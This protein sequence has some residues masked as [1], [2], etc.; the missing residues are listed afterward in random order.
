MV[1]ARHRYGLFL[2]VRH[3]APIKSPGC[4]GIILEFYKTYWDVTKGKLRLYNP[5]L[6][7]AKITSAQKMI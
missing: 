3:G 2:A 5:K 6:Q 1:G 4:N 7:K